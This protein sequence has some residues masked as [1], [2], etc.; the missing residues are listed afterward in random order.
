MTASYVIVTFHDDVIRLP[1]RSG[2]DRRRRVGVDRVLKS[3]QGEVVADFRGFFTDNRDWQTI[4]RGSQLR[5]LRPEELERLSAFR[6]RAIVVR[7]PVILRH[8][9]LEA[10]DLSRLGMYECVTTH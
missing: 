10:F 5:L 6:L 9:L 1:Q 4:A 7:H 2:S 8:A 3:R